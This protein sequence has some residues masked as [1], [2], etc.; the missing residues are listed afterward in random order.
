MIPITRT[1]PDTDDA[2]IV[3]D[4]RAESD[5]DSSMEMNLEVVEKKVLAA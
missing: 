3:V 2:T 5:D 4:M 1:P